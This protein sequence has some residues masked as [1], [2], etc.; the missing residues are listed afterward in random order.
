MMRKILVEKIDVLK[1]EKILK[2]ERVLVIEVLL[3]MEKIMEMECHQ[4]QG[5]WCWQCC[6]GWVSLCFHLLSSLSFKIEIISASSRLTLA[7]CSLEFSV[8]FKLDLLSVAMVRG[9]KGTKG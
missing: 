7:S 6:G 3:V 1:S 8:T 4:H 9:P 2:K 5:M